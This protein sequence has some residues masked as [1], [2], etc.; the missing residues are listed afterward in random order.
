MLQWETGRRSGDTLL[1]PTHLTST[2]DNTGSSTSTPA[3]LQGQPGEGVTAGDAVAVVTVGPVLAD[4]GGVPTPAACPPHL[5]LQAA[6]AL[7]A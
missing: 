2:A 7:Q 6:H 1:V 5:L 3:V 4:S